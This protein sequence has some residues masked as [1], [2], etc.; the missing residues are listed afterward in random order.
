ED[1]NCDEFNLRVVG[2]LCAKDL[3]PQLEPLI[4]KAYKKQFLNQSIQITGLSDE[5]FKNAMQG[6]AIIHRHMSRSFKDGAMQ[7]WAPSDFDGHPAIDVTTRFFNHSKA[8]GG[9]ISIPFDTNI[10]PKGILSKLV[11]DKWVHTPDNT[12]DY[13]QFIQ[14][15][16]EKFKYIKCNPAIFRI[17][18]IVEVEVGFIAIPIA[19]SQVRLGLVLRSLTALD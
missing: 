16:D 15:E 14:K 13:C 3:P 9:T 6:I 4:R 5:T 18:D 19:S 17:G 2:I 1:G 8:P 12:V 7:S 10:D 11:D